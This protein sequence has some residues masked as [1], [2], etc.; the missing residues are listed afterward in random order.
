MIV[1]DR[2]SRISARAVSP[3]VASCGSARV[4]QALAAL[5]ALIGIGCTSTLESADELLVASPHR[6]EI[7]EEIERAFSSWYQE[8][9]GRAV[10]TIWLDLGGSSNIRK[11]LSDRL[12][13]GSTAGVDIFF[14]GGTDPFESLRRQ[15]NLVPYRLPDEMLVQLQPD[16]HGVPL[17]DPQY[18]WYGVVLSSFGIMFNHEVLERVGLPVP[19][20]WGDLGS[21][22]YARA[23][24]GWIGAAD[25]RHSSSVH[26]IY[27]NIL[28]AYGWEQGFAVLAR[29]AA[30]SREFVRE[31]ASVPR[32]VQIGDV[33]CAPVIDLYAFSLIAR[34]GRDRIGFVLPEG[35]TIIT[36]DAVAIVRGAPNLE[37][38]QSF[39]RFLMDA[40]GQKVWM[41][42]RGVPGGPQ[43]Y[44]LSRPSV[45][46]DLY[47]LPKDQVAVTINPFDTKAALRYDGKLASQRFSILNDILGA[48]LIDSQPE[49][50]RA[51]MLLQ[52]VPD[53]DDL[54]RELAR[55][56]CSENELMALAEITGHS[57]QRRNIA[58]AEWMGQARHRYQQ[59]AEAA[60]RRKSQ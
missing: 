49:L 58:I 53:N 16:L 19:A 5:A 1:D 8:E 24:G 45:L 41:L 10:R 29:S 3:L 44:D 32:Q 55:P 20:V 56:P 42:R 4:R 60:E 57:Q 43:R 28:Q 7:K 38:A 23:G 2:S 46:R 26:V 12:A 51:W 27:E 13:S 9:T 14:G 40:K 36:P 50:R 15:R 6:D 39:I 35:Q 47:E 31:S 48:T 25:P 59:V 30:N 52:D 33:A 11:Y 22:A 21:P 34:E 17:Y 18:H 54:I 37:V